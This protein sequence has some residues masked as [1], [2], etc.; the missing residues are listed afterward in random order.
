MR[1]Y[2][3]VMGLL[4]GGC[5][6]TGLDKNYAAYLATQAD[7]ESKWAAAAAEKYRADAEKAKAI[8]VIGSLGGDSAKVAAV[9]ALGGSTAPLPID[10]QNV[11]R[12]APSPLSVPPRPEGWGEVA[13]RWAGTIGAIANPWVAGFY[14]FRLGSEQSRNNRDAVIAQTNAYSS[15]ASSGFATAG[16]IS[17]D[18]FS[19]IQNVNNAAW[20]NVGSLKPNITVTNGAV[21]TGAGNASY[22]TTANSHNRTCTSGTAGN[23]APGGGGGQGTTT[24]GSG[25]AGGIGGASGQASC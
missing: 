1:V 13:L 11:G 5:A 15:I 16:S 25:G 6:S 17:R 12:L 8:S 2:L 4:L 10:S 3:G 23:G 24:G 9:L 7:I 20:A 21:S 14:G 22:T 18:G 19:A